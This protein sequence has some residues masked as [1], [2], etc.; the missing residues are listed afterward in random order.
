MKAIIMAGGEGRRLRPLTQRLPKPMVPVAGRPAMEHI[1]LLLRQHG[2]TD[3]GVTL[4]YLP[5]AIRQYF[6]D[7][8]RLGVHLQYFVED[9][10]L[11]TAGS[12]KHAAGFIDD[13]FLVIS[14]DTITGVDLSAAQAYHRE[15][16]AAVTMVLKQM[17]VP[18]EYG[19]AVTN[20]QGRI[21]CLL[22]KPGW[23]EVLSDTVNTG[24]YLIE[25]S[26]LSHIPEGEPFDFSRDLFPYLLEQKQPVYGYLT[27]SYWCDIGDLSAYRQCQ[28][29]FLDGKTGLPMHGVTTGDRIY[30]TG[31]LTVGQN[32][33]LGH[34]LYIGKNVCIGK[35]CIL[36]P[37][38]VIGDNCVLEDGAHISG[39][40]LWDGVEAGINATLRACVVCSEATIGNEGRILDGAAIGAGATIGERAVVH[41]G[42][43]VANGKTVEEGA[44]LTVNLIHGDHFGG[45]VFTASAAVGRF[46][47]DI[48][49]EIC[50]RLAS[51]LGTALTQQKGQMSEALCIASAG[52]ASCDLLAAAALAGLMG[53][54]AS[55]YYIGQQ[56][57]DVVRYTIRANQM[58][59]GLYVS[60]DGEQVTLR[61]LGT[62]G[63][64]LTRAVQRELE[65]CYH[66]GEAVRC[67]QNRLKA[68]RSL[69]NCRDAYIR[70]AIESCTINR[71]NMQIA[72]CAL[73]E[74]T[75]EMLAKSLS[76]VGAKVTFY[77]NEQALCTAMKTNRYALGVVLRN[78]KPPV[79]YDESGRPFSEDVAFGIAAMICM[80]A[81]KKSVLY[82]PVYASTLV[83]YVARNM[84]CSVVRIKEFMPT[85]AQYA[86]GANHL[87]YTL[88]YDGVLSVL[89]MLEFL[90]YNQISMSELAGLL[91][92]VFKRRQ[93]VPCP[94]TKKGRV[95]SGL[96]NQYEHVDLT[97]GVKVTLD[98]GWVLVLPDQLADT[99]HIVSESSKEEYAEELCAFFAEKIQAL[100]QTERE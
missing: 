6:G 100:T 66:R 37:Y 95:V 85:I 59:G 56:P 29:D 82:A 90:Q 80:S 14:G 46:G 47:L 64:D 45:D 58:A 30:S 28:R 89:R 9:T 16:A 78:G 5:D 53:S 34:P 21:T 13:T 60:A 96:L 27:D 57:L 10:P 20:Q 7:G 24:I 67:G 33:M 73:E 40:V 81:Y 93:E 2:I 39:A 11:G 63:A 52:G 49:P 43:Q 38:S 54:G 41:P 77:A 86:G 98:D 44:A 22:E 84:E 83:N 17:E 79:Y 42:I 23:S 19:V 1:I 48:S 8:S 88:L 36:E 25:P 99:C 97:D 65:R 70:Y 76:A 69:A 72:A 31:K 68:C 61:F 3:I 26:V 50:T 35:G 75:E 32:A 12:V 62:A 18:L 4:Q 91:P 74:G 51:A 92:Q 87:L 71:F 55:V 15:K 94:N